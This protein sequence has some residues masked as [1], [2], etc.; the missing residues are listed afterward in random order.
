VVLGPLAQITLDQF[1]S[2]DAELPQF[3]IEYRGRLAM[4]QAI[5]G[6]RDMDFTNWPPDVP[7]PQ[8][9][10]ERLANSRKGWRST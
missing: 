9:D 8:A 6:G 3:E 4:A 10:W 1:L 2:Q 7:L 5:I